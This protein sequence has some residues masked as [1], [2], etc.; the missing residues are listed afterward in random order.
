MHA[1]VIAT[2]PSTAARAYTLTVGGSDVNVGGQSGAAYMVD[3]DSMVVEE[4]GPGGVSSMSF[5]IWD[6][7]LE[8]VLSEGQQV[9]FWDT[10]NSLPLFAGFV[11]SWSYSG[12]I[13]RT[14]EVTCVGSEKQLDWMVVP[15]LTVPSGIDTR[16]AIQLLVANATGIGAQLRAFATTGSGSSSQAEPIGDM[17]PGAGTFDVGVAVAL[18]GETLREAIRK[19]IESSAVGAPIGTTGATASVTVDFWWGLRTYPSTSTS[20]P[21]DYVGQTIAESSGTR[22]SRLDHE[23]D[24]TGAVHQVYV[25][26]GNA[27]GTGLV[28][29]GSGISGEVAY[30]EDTSITTSDARDRAGTAY[31]ADH[32]TATRGSYTVENFAPTTNI[33]AGATT[34]ITNTAAGLT[35]AIYRIASIRKTFIAAKQT[36][37]VAYGGLRP[38]FVRASRR[39]TRSIR[40]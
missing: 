12:V 19:V 35:A 40:S 21:T 24:A 11:Q 37:T 9:E 7:N 28:S 32:V 31:L 36:W 27:A 39:L 30:I 38:S 8:I 17:A 14:V 4:Q 10:T 29:D 18:N 22:A 13:G 16:S 20:M 3:I 6:P 34:T 15:T 33:R 26:G 25:K 23:T 2:L 5:D 1:A